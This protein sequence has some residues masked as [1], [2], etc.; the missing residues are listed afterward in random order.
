MENEMLRGVRS[1]FGLGVGQG[2]VET[3][4]KYAMEMT[5]L[6]RRGLKQALLSE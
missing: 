3:L 2:H 5:R 6:V 4:E 1:G